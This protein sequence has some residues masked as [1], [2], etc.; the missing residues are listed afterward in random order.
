MPS[1]NNAPIL[2]QIKVTLKHVQPEI[3]RRL[4]LPSDLS[5]YQLHCILQVTMGWEDIGEHYFEDAAGNCY[6]DASAALE[7][8]D[9]IQYKL[10]DVLHTK[11]PSLEYGYDEEDGWQH[12]IQLEKTLPYFSDD[13]QPVILCLA[14]ERA[15]PPESSRGV[16]GYLELQ[17]AVQRLSAEVF[18]ERYP[19]FNYDELHKDSFDVDRANQ[20]LDLVTRFGPLMTDPEIRAA[21]DDAKSE[22]EALLQEFEFE[23]DEMRYEVIE[24]FFRSM[25]EQ[26]IEDD[27][28]GLSPNQLHDL[29]YTPF[30]AADVIRFHPEHA[31]PDQ[32]PFLAMFKVLADE[33]LN[34]NNK[35]TPKGNLPLTVVRA[36]HDALDT[37]RYFYGFDVYQPRLRSE[38][39]SLPVHITRLLAQHSGLCRVQKGRLVLTRKS[40]AALEKQQW[41]KLYQ[42]MIE[43]LITKLNWGYLDG[44]PELQSI[45]L[46]S[47]FLMRFLKTRSDWVTTD[48]CVE[49][50]VATFP[51]MLE[52]ADDSNG[53][54][55]ESTLWHAFTHRIQMLLGL[56]GL[57]E[58]QHDYETSS[59]LER[60]VL[61]SLKRTPLSDSFLEWISPVK[62]KG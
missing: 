14:G 21:A 19:W 57:I 11:Q 33:I 9:E 53:Y 51:M 39:D 18:S 42:P 16:E 43:C 27:L 54:D 12:L 26:P 41:S 30:Q 34:G 7:E 62:S 20:D 55:P 1:K 24:D 17:S 46:T 31:T 60:V 25:F 56:T 50:L 22:L 13:D 58:Y 47:L 32:V 36:M 15:C 8:L 23:T 45:R 40:E 38:E 2:L 35:L 4:L 28:L 44:N 52:E 37:Q 6:G 5:L 29:L 10:S 48:Q 49:R 61:V 59:P 3:W